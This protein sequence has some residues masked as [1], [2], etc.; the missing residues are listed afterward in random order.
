MKTKTSFLTALL[1]VGGFVAH[2]GAE[3]LS[4]TELEPDSNY[5]HLRFPAITEETLS[6]DRPVLKGSESKDIID[7]YGKCNES[8]IGENQI[9]SQK[10]QERSNKE[11]RE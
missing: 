9:A 2:G 8:P 7:F 6:S 1:L 3:V 10:R 5:C 11:S 4:R